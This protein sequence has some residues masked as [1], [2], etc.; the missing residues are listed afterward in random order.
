M[1][2]EK[3]EEVRKE[4]ILKRKTEN[5]NNSSEK[6][7]EKI[8]REEE[9]RNKKIHEGEIRLEGSKKEKH[10]KIYKLFYY[11]RISQSIILKCAS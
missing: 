1:K 11:Y 7:K 8:E 9:E 2:I 4:G 6:G 10:K 5:E 3:Q